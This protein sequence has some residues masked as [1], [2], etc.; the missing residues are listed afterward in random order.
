MK[1]YMEDIVADVY[2]EFLRRNP[3]YCPCRRC[4]DDVMALA[5][6]NLKGKYAVTPEGHIFAGVLRNDR[7]LRTDA[8]VV[9]LDVVKVVAQNPKHS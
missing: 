8:L 1:N 5:L 3:D 2:K 9:I 6:N 4:A 7:Q